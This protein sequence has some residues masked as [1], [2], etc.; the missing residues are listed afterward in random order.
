MHVRLS[1]RQPFTDRGHV[2]LVVLE[3]AAGDDLPGHPLLRH[4]L[5]AM[6][7]VQI[8]VAERLRRCKEISVGLLLF[9]QDLLQRAVPVL[10]G[11]STL[12]NF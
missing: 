12:H 4:L 10:P 5:E 2:V 7:V 1:L 8:F 9:V 11:L 6:R 3:R